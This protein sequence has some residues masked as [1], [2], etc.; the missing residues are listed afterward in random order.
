MD[1][2]TTLSRVGGAELLILHAWSLWGEHTLRWR[3]QIPE[4]EMDEIRREAEAVQR[5]H[6]DAFV[7][8]H[9]L[10]DVRHRSV[11]EPGAFVSPIA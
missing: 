1:M 11:L 3:A 4:D 8:G 2:A 6:L 10:V 9:E 5:R 7:S